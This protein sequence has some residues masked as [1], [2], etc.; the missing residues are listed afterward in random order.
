MRAKSNA[1]KKII[2]TKTPPLSFVGFIIK[3]KDSEDNHK[4]EGEW[5]TMSEKE[6]QILET[7]EK[8]IPDL[9]E[10]EKEKLL[11]F[12]EGMAFMKGKQREEVSEVTA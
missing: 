2:S 4:K 12:G 1:S 8:V 9:S 3:P 11:S 5:Q 10:M 7:F 6:K